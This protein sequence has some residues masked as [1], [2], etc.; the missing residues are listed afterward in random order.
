MAGI[1]TLSR[2]T[3][4]GI[5]MLLCLVWSPYTRADYEGLIIDSIANCEEE[6]VVIHS[7]HRKAKHHKRHPH[8]CKTT[9][10]KHKHRYVHKHG[11]HPKKCDVCQKKAIGMCAGCDSQSFIIVE[12]TGYSFNCFRKIGKGIKFAT[13]PLPPCFKVFTNE[14][15][16]VTSVQPAP[17]LERKVIPVVNIFKRN[18]GC[19]LACYS[20]NPD[21]SIYPVTGSIFLVG[22]IRVRGTYVGTMCVPENYESTDI[23]GEEKFKELCSKAFQC[24]GNSC[25]AGPNTG[26]WFG[27]Q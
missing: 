3:L 12:P 6:G 26:D 10:H 25:W 17:G 21:K 11:H 15:G 13:D 18:P 8:P 16:T 23:R 5:L 20:H 9:H 22:Q 4:F 1:L 27:L 7:H 14:Q 2:F 19:Y 24:I